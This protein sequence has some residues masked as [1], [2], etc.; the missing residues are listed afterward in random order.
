MIPEGVVIN[1]PL[2]VQ[3]LLMVELLAARRVVTLEMTRLSVRGVLALVFV[4]A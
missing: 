3:F 2:T 4:V 1:H